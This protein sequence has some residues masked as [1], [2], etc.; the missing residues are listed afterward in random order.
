ME[1]VQISV[2]LGCLGLDNDGLADLTAKLRREILDTDVDSA[3]P[4]PAGVAPEG[5]K[6]GALVAI[7]ALVVTV[8]PAVVESLMGVILSWLSRQP[9][10]VEIEIDGNRFRGR[11]SKAQ[12][13]ELVATYLRRVDGGS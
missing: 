10:D 3:E 13:D 7:G 8:T 6:S 12:R 9:S 2:R 11:V 4:A 1:Q 5:A